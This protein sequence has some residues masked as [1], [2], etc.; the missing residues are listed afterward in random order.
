[1]DQG[2]ILCDCDFFE[3]IGFPPLQLY[4][5]RDSSYREGVEKSSQRYTKG[6]YPLGKI[7]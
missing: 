1:M 2:G 6:C 5:Q 7:S 4:F 3:S